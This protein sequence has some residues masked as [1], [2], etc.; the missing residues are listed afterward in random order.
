MGV[1][2]TRGSAR[3]SLVA[4]V[5]D[6]DQLVERAEGGDHLGGTGEEGDDPHARF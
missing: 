2:V 6:A 1:V 5:R 3:T 4:L